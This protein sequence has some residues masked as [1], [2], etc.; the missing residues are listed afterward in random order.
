MKPPI[1]HTTTTT[2]VL[3]WHAI[4]H[5]T[6]ILVIDLLILCVSIWFAAL[7]YRAYWQGRLAKVQVKG[8]N[9][10]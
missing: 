1:V 6:N 7:A 4:H 8:F 5:V 3:D 2:S 9:K 10:I